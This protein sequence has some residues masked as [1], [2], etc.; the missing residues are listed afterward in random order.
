MPFSNDSLKINSIPLPI[1][2]VKGA[3][4]THTFC[5]EQAVQILYNDNYK[6]ESILFSRYSQ[7]LAEGIIWADKGFKSLYHFYDVKTGTGKWNWPDSTVTCEMYFSKALELWTEEKYSRSMFYLGAATHLIQ[8]MC[9]PHHACCVLSDGHIEFEKWV[10]DRR[11]E[12]S[13]Y[14]GGIYL[15][16]SSP[17]EWIR[18]NA[19]YSSEFYPFV[20]GKSNDKH[21]HLSACELLPRTQ[22]TT[23]GF[24][25]MFYQ[26]SHYK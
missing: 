17:K 20:H 13:V 16:T 22:R 21:Y 23:S 11:E 14:D 18:R 12:Y 26:L 10:R 8:D 5:N 9:V 7:Q 3:S 6:K 2:C 15:N 25:L 24:W 4:P 19:E 1:H